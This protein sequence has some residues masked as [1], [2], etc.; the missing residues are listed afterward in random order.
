M[1]LPYEKFG[2]MLAGL[3]VIVETDHKP[4]VHVVKQIYEG[5]TLAYVDAAVQL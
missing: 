2:N 1:K 3:Q 5:A 4:S